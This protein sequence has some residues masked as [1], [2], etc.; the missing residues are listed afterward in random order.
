[1]KAMIL[2]AG[3]GTRLRPLT[4]D[5]PK[6]L[7]EIGGTTLLELNIRRLKQVGVRAIIINVHHHAQQIIDFVKARNA[8]GLHIE[9]SV[10][11]ELLDTGG[12]LKKASLFFADVPYFLVHNVD[13]LSDLNYPDLF[14]CLQKKEALAC[15]AVR[16]RKTQRYLLFNDRLELAGWQNV[17]SAE[18]RLVTP[19]E[20]NLKPFSFMGIQALSN[21]IF[22]YFPERK[23]FSL[24]EAYLQLAGLKQKVCGLVAQKA[25]WLDVGKKESLS[26]AQQ[27]F[28]E[29]F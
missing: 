27:L 9:F 21:Q 28:K 5:R 29:W 7:V 26:Q 6:A 14:A 24:I 15:L 1:M 13:V 3:L 8:F 10:E 18:K 11:E 20:E 12:G 23:K 16:R 17:Q 22:N 2:A 4:N 19:G 25:R